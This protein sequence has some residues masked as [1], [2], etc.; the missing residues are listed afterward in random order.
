MK[1]SMCGV[2]VDNN[3]QVIDAEASFHGR[4]FKAL[5]KDKSNIEDLTHVS[6]YSQPGKHAFMP[7]PEYFY[8][9]PD[10]FKVTSDIVGIDGLSVPDMFVGKYHTDECINNKV[11]EYLQRYK[12]VPSMDFEKYVI[13][14]ELFITWEELYDRIP[15]YINEVLNQIEEDLKNV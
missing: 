10:L 3:G 13:K 1:W 12:F 8:L 4:Y 15:Q 2:Y 6:I 11:K 14:S 9:L 5:L 7:K